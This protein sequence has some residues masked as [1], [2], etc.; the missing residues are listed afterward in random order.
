MEEPW[1]QNCEVFESR[2]NTIDT[3][4]TDAEWWLKQSR[5]AFIES[6]RAN[7]TIR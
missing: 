6:F 1:Q 5:I 3:A 2:S 4:E 7:V